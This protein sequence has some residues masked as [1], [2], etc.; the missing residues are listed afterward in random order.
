MASRWFSTSFQIVGTAPA[1]SAP[2]SWIART[3]AGAC[4]K[5]SGMTSVAP[6]ISAAYGMP[7]AI[8]WNI[9]TMVRTRLASVSWNDCGIVTCIE[10]R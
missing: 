2:A 5:R 6:L 7:Q 9:G 4:R 1:K 3:R 10:C 8:A